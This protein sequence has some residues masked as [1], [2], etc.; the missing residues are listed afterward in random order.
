MKIFKTLLLGVALFSASVAMAN[1][2]KT[3]TV[4]SFSGIRSTDGFIVNVTM[5]DVEE[6]EVEAPSD[7]IDR[8]I[9]ETVKGTLQLSFKG[10]SVNLIGKRVVVNV[11][12]KALNNLQ[13]AAGSRMEVSGVVASDNVS[14]DAGSGATIKTVVEAK[15][16]SLRSTSGAELQVEGAAN[17]VNVRAGSGASVHATD[18]STEL[19]SVEASSGALVHISAKDF[20]NVKVSSGARVRYMEDANVKNVSVSSGGSFKKK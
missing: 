1:D 11:K 15:T 4:D 3:V 5:G 10:S 20:E 8:V 9:V 19:A 18:F 12:A 2:K 6:V 13:A 7:L 16:L 14:I 17:S